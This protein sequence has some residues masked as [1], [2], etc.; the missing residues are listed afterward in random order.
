MEGH[1]V[2]KSRKEA[3]GLEV[4]DDAPNAY[5]AMKGDVKEPPPLAKATTW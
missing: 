5:S 2:E 1:G 3:K 4:P